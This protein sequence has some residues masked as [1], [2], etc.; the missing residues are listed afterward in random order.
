MNT[1]EDKKTTPEERKTLSVPEAGRIYF[2]LSRNG[3]YQAARSGTLPTIEVGRR[4]Y[5][6][7]R[8]IE[9]KLDSV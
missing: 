5:V 3:S 7:I 6:P 9:K 1:M 4:K 8:A 2:G